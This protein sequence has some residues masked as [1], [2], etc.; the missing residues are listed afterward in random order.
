MTGDMNP[1]DA[2]S[3]EKRQR[4]DGGLFLICRRPRKPLS[5]NVGLPAGDRRER[6][7]G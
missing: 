1:A 6:R 5:E 2:V 3:R 7:K 4:F